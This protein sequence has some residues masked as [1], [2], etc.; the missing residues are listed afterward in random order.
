MASISDVVFM[1]I[2]VNGER[3]THFRLEDL[4]VGTTAVVLV[5]A[6]AGVAVA[7]GAV[8]G[9]GGGWEE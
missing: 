3:V 8:V 2:D 7:G 1:R 9:R 4:R 6:A 5:A